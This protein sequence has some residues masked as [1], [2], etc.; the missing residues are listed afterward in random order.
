MSERIK[1]NSIT[2]KNKTTDFNDKIM[3]EVVF[4]T[5]AP[6]TRPLYWNVLYVGSAYS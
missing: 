5:Y 2:M 6:I 4:T 3:L 1:V